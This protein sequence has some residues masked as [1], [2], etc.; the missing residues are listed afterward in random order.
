MHHWQ[1]TRCTDF[2]RF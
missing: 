2:L 1:C